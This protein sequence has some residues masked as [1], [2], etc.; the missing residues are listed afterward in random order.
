MQTFT[1]ASKNLDLPEFGN[2]VHLEITI[3]CGDSLLVERLLQKCLKLEVLVAEKVC[4]INS[5][6]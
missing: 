4:L 6:V 5:N 2:L 3:S 1:K